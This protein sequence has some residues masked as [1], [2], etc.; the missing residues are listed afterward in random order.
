MFHL[1]YFLPVFLFLS[2]T[3]CAGKTGVYQDSNMD[4]ASIRTVAVLPLANLTKEQQ[5]TDRVRDVF[6]TALIASSGIYVIP[7][8]EVMRGIISTGMAN[9]SSPSA[10]EVIKFCKTSKT[11]AL[12]TGVVREYG[13]VRSGTAMSTVISMSMQLM[14]GQTGK[15]VWSA[16]TTQ[17]GI[18]IG[19]RLLG[20]G[21]QALNVITEK[22]VYE[23]I[24]KLFQ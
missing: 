20:G 3:A 16:D 17:G 6:A 8:G 11:D 21:G 2:L 12:F 14:E 5:A 1:G 22:A 7:P 4:F 24:K 9:P 10:D 13:E 18:S 15:V 19:D 23:I